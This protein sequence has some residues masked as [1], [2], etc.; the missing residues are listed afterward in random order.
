MLVVIGLLVLGFSAW[1]DGDDSLSRLTEGGV[2]RI[3]Y[4]VEPPYAF[5]D[6]NGELSGE[7]PAVARRVAAMLGIREVVWIQ[8][9][10]D[11]LIP[12]LETGRFDVAAA[13]LFITPER[14]RRVAFSRPTFRVTPGLLVRTDRADVPTDCH[15]AAARRDFRV[16]VLEGAVEESWLR[17]CGLLDSQLER[18]PAARVGFEAVVSGHVDGLA[19]SAPT[20]RWFSLADGERRAKVRSFGMGHLENHGGV[21]FRRQDRALREAWDRALGSWLG[22]PEHRRTVEAFGFVA[23]ELV[24]ADGVAEAP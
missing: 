13:G 20:L 11:Q 3:G 5:V 21:A 14:G 12:E 15:D 8:T 7:G 6:E 23:D 18:V 2:L 24:L 22:S 17:A 16:A 19:L 9:R 10:F 4:A 1:T